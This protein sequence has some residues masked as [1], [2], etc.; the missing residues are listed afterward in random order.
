VVP[1]SEYFSKKNE[2]S[3]T[4]DSPKGKLNIEVDSDQ[5]RPCRDLRIS[6]KATKVVSRMHSAHYGSHS[7]RGDSRGRWSTKG[8]G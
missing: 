6:R 3:M 7:S 4:L 5:K 1:R 2:Y 8:S